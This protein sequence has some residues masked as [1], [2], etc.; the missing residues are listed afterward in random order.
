MKSPLHQYI[1]MFVKNFMDELFYLEKVARGDIPARKNEDPWQKFFEITQAL[2]SLAPIPGLPMGFLISKEIAKKCIEL[3]KQALDLAQKAHEGVQTLLE[4]V[5]KAE[6]GYDK[7]HGNDAK[8][9]DTLVALTQAS[10]DLV[11]T[12]LLAGLLARGL[13]QRYEHVIRSRLDLDQPE[14]SLLPFAQMSVI[15][16]FDYLHS[17]PFTDIKAQ[18]SLLQQRSRLMTGIC[19]G[20]PKKK[21]SQQLTEKVSRL[22][23]RVMRNMGEDSL[24]V[25][26][27]LTATHGFFKKHATSKDIFTAN[28][29]HTRTGWYDEKTCYESKLLETK[30]WEDEKQKTDYPKYGYAYLDSH[31][32]RPSA[33]LKEKKSAPS[34]LE[35]IRKNRFYQPVGI[36]HIAKYLN[37]DAVKRAKSAEKTTE[38][39]FRK[40]LEEDEEYKMPTLCQ[41]VCHDNL[42]ALSVSWAFGNFTGVDFSGAVLS[43]DMT[44]CCFAQAY[45]LG[46]VF[47]DI[48]C[49][50]EKAPVNF[51]GATLA[52]AQMIEYPLT[53]A[54][55]TQT[56]LSFANLSSAKLTAIHHEGAKWYKTQLTGVTRD[57]LFKKQAEQ[58]QAM[59]K[60]ILQRMRRLD[61]RITL[62]ELELKPIIACIEKLDDIILKTVEESQQKDLREQ[63]E[64]LVQLVIQKI[65]LESMKAYFKEEV[66]KLKVSVEDH[67][68]EIAKCS[69]TLGRLTE[70]S[71][72]TQKELTSY[73]KDV[74]ELTTKFHVLS[75]QYENMVIRLPNLERQI[76][77]TR[78]N[79][80][81]VT[82]QLTTQKK[83]VPS[84]R[85]LL[86]I[87]QQEIKDQ[88]A[89]WEQEIKPEKA[90]DSA[91]QKLSTSLADQLKFHETQSGM[92]SYCQQKLDD[93]RE[94]IN[95]ANTVEELKPLQLLLTDLER[96]LSPTEEKSPLSDDFT[97]PF[98]KLTTEQRG[99]FADKISEL[100]KQWQTAITK[101]KETQT[102]QVLQLQNR[103][104]TM[105]AM[106][107]Q[108]QHAIETQ[109][110]VM[111]GWKQW[112]EGVNTVLTGIIEETRGRYPV[113]EKGLQGL[114]DEIKGIQK[115]QEKHQKEQ[116]SQRVEI[117]QEI[118][119][120]KS[121]V[122]WQVDL[123]GVEALQEQIQVL[124][125]KL[126]KIEDHS[127][128][129][130]KI[131]EQ[132]TAL[133][134]AYAKQK[135]QL[136]VLTEK[137]TELKQQNEK[138]LT[139]LEEQS[140]LLNE[141]KTT[142]EKQQG[143]QTKLSRLSLERLQ[144][145][146][147]AAQADI[148]SI[149]SGFQPAD[150]S[151]HPL[152]PEE[153]HAVDVPGDHNCLFW[154][155]AL[156][157]LL[158][159]VND[160]KAFERMY[161]H[162]FGSEGTLTLKA[163]SGEEK[164]QIILIRSPATR[165]NVRVMLMVYDCRKSTPKE[166]EGGVLE[167]LVC[168]IFRRRVANEML[169]I[170]DEKQRNHLSGDNWPGYYKSMRQPIA[171]GGAPEIQAI[172]HLAEVN[173]E[174]NGEGY[175][176]PQCWLIDKAEITLYLLH[177]NAN[178]QEKGVKNH[179]HFGLHRDIYQA[180]TTGTDIKSTPESKYDLPA[181]T[182]VP[183]RNLEDLRSQLNAEIK[184]VKEDQENFQKLQ[185]KLAEEIKKV[186]DILNLTAS[187]QSTSSPVTQPD[188][189]TST[190]IS[191]TDKKSDASNGNNILR[192]LINADIPPLTLR[193]DQ[194][195]LQMSV[196][197]SLRLRIDTLEAKQSETHIITRGRDTLLELHV[198]PLQPA[199]IEACEKGDFK[200]VITAIKEK[201]ALPNV[202]DTEGK[203]PIA[204]AVYGMNP[205]IIQ[206]L[207]K[208]IPPG[209]S[210]TWEEIIKHNQEKYNRPHI[211]PDFK[212]TTYKDWF[213]WL[214]SVES[215]A[216]LRNIHGQQAKAEWEWNVQ[217]GFYAGPI[218][219]RNQ[220]SYFYIA[221]GQYLDKW[222]YFPP[223]ATISSSDTS[224]LAVVALPHLHGQRQIEL[225]YPKLAARIK[226]V[227]DGLILRIKNLV[228]GDLNPAR[229]PFGI[230]TSAASGLS[231]SSNST[232]S[233][234][235]SSVSSSS[236]HS[237]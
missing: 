209:G 68:V 207:F 150:K 134:E 45:L 19:S 161:T 11:A 202:P 56:D 106:L 158:P 62:V 138:A 224:I 59:R 160:E 84:S 194:F 198:A 65:D 26:S 33:D 132:L 164:D 122:A 203:M 223:Q 72:E 169:E 148:N 231:S 225:N 175:T 31:Q 211:A 144:K 126:K 232:Y 79:L 95:T 216:F 35:E 215:N 168:K 39:T 104:N 127:A 176:K 63:E 113:I 82:I 70:E 147:T 155:A 29:F 66:D 218:I 124:S 210:M 44:G 37:S 184:K 236:L 172:A 145:E 149:K 151:K 165:E 53:K 195:S 140:R 96:Q 15:R 57:D 181:D 48:T 64:K 9:K 30:W 8:D 214:K 81:E 74:S 157:L 110:K 204:A 116:D 24:P 183:L 83:E 94:A 142:F 50:F 112:G 186:Q 54:D 105:G 115:A 141:W 191:T 234:N 220:P 162:L 154:S 119:N 71:Q 180:L 146:L 217:D 228:T 229:T 7:L 12:E 233:S 137:N 1:D 100:G 32:H 101:L 60:E 197:E 187:I 34:E 80:Q 90:I 102:K 221:S 121:K 192:Q 219:T 14:K 208:L 139:K 173:I 28:E 206:Y 205:D 129:E 230:Y 93:L 38:Y 226:Q 166:S 61:S 174:V 135:D 49:N 114:Q 69:A 10:S 52:F 109:A 77:E 16:C 201:G 5:D 130:D 85:K 2:L 212:P 120:L 185:Q 36:S 235:S 73:A 179:Y 20:D 189:T 88:L 42:T 46:T 227:M 159:V 170:F 51:Q 199:L 143:E 213:D 153:Y 193:S 41:V 182:T 103:V 4:V 23:P 118:D 22:L 237:V 97:A 91:S 78:R 43:G 86:K 136:S 128:A 67:S 75:G 190:V 47:I 107:A 163:R 40:F 222:L 167:T 58:T 25:K 55:L 123:A 125:A 3:G 13:A 108:R 152:L 188:S 177:V 156:G 76:S 171:W 111:E 98:A 99:E 21:W 133:Q 131:K 117:L 200:A 6:A 196:L 27:D 17:Q 87:L 89:A 92:F 178:N 18:E